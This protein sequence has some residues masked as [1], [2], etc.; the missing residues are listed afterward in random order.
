MPTYSDVKGL[1]V[2]TLNAEKIGTV[3]D[4]IVDTHKLRVAWLRVSTGGLLGGSSLRLPVK[5]I[6][7]IDEHSVTIDGTTVLETD[8]GGPLPIELAA[9]EKD[10]IG[11]RVISENGLDLGTVRDY[12]FA[13]NGW[14]LVALVLAVPDPEV[15]PKT[16]DL[17]LE[18][19]RVDINSVAVIAGDRQEQTTQNRDGS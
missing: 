19:Y 13:I 2:V 15:V 1:D 11:K 18:R 16:Y 4:L 7:V 10:L 9:S 8:R 5:A 3:G 12:S 17:D 14:A 6:R